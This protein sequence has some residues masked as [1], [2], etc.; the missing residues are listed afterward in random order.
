MQNKG[1]Y[2]RLNQCF[3]EI[4]MVYLSINYDLI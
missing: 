4:E 2:S 3:I 1:I